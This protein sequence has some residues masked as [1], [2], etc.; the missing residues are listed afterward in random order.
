MSSLNFQSMISLGVE[1]LFVA[2]G[3]LVLFYFRRRISLAPLFIFVGS[4]QFL[5][6]VLASSVY[7]VVGHDTV[8][9]PG[10]MVLFSS[11]LFIILLVYLRTDI[12]TT[13]G[14]IIGI[15]VANITLAALL[16][17][18]AYQLLSY[19]TQM[20]LDMPIELFAIS[21]RYFLFGTLML[22]IDSLLVVLLYESLS[23]RASKL[24][25]GAHIV[26]TLATVLCLDAV[27][28]SYV[29]AGGEAYFLDVL[30]GQV[31][32][33]LSSGLIFAFFL[34]TYLRVFEPG[35]RTHRPE[36]SKDI[37]SIFTH[38]ER[39]HQV[40][41]QLKV[42]EAANVA[43]SRF[44]AHMSHELRT[45]LNAIIGFTNVLV[46]RRTENDE[47]RLLLTRVLHNGKH[48]LVLING[49]LDL[50]RID[51]GKIELQQEKVN[52]G[53]L[54]QE[55][56]DQLE[57][58]ALGKPVVLKVVQP[59]ETCWLETDRL[60]LQQVLIN[61]LGNA[62]KFTDKGEITAS[63]IAGAEPGTVARID[64]ADSGAGIPEDDL[65]SIFEPF[66]QVGDSGVSDK[67]TGLGLAISQAL[68]KQL[69][70]QMSVDSELGKGSRF[71]IHITLNAM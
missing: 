5:G 3:A 45:P 67:G 40:R 71:S 11:Y 36:I 37:L 65:Q 41:E 24:P 58:Q 32:G 23:F 14:L 51:S 33:K 48:L 52:V 16:W 21:P 12:P 57:G 6:Q 43:K 59:A 55:T 8:V 60:R 47:D 17:F 4:N 61:L 49:L 70:Y 22:L 28:F 54:L 56:M 50:S 19:E 25:Q 10:S 62:I 15:L 39:Y 68:C 27:V 29:L 35:L 63:I 26:L 42:S 2:I 46:N 64:I 9:S 13:R 18:T 30:R 53:E 7:L 1:V 44:L 69:G 31:L 20:V 34:M 38:R 66:Y